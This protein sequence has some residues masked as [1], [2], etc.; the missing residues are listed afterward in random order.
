MKWLAP[1]GSTQYSADHRYSVTEAVKGIWIAYELGPTT[2]TEIG[3][4]NSDEGARLLCE[5]QDAFR[6]RA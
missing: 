3:R 1:T 2:G 4:S 5:D 6:K